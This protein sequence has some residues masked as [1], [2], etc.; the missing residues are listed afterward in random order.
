M[1]ENQS[2]NRQKF[3]QL[4]QASMDMAEGDGISYLIY[5]IIKI[6]LINID[7]ITSGPTDSEVHNRS[8]RPPMQRERLSTIFQDWLLVLYLRRMISEE[9]KM[10]LWRTS[11][12][13]QINK[14]MI[15]GSHPV[16]HYPVYLWYTDDN[17][18]QHNGWL[19]SNGNSKWINQNTR[20]AI[21]KM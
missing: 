13:E 1:G 10:T 11:N 14:V 3:V 18:Y 2:A 6:F 15:R 4:I 5:F 9:Y 8:E 21:P 17:N 12:D 19:N 7:S 16:V 20:F